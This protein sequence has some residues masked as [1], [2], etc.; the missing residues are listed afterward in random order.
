LIFVSDL[1]AGS[2][3]RPVSAD[4]HFLDPPWIWDRWLA[5]E[6][7]D[8]APKLVEDGDGGQ[9]WLY[10]GS[11]KP[12]PIGLH[13]LPG[14]PVDALRPSGV[15]YSEV[16]PGTYD[17]SARLL[18]LDED[19]VAA[20]VIFPTSRPLAHFLDDHDRGFLLAGVEAYNRFVIEEFCAAAP[21][22]LFAVAQLPS[23]GADDC[24]RTL[25]Q[26]AE[27]GFVSVVLPGWPSGSDLMR[28]EDLR[29]WKCAADLDMPVCI[30]VA[31][32]SREERVLSLEYNKEQVAQPAGE[33]KSEPRVGG[34]RSTI[35]SLEA[36]HRLPNVGVAM[37]KG[38][39]ALSELL[40]SGLFE[41]CPSLKVGL[42]ETWVGWIPRLLEAL[43]DVWYR[44]RHLHGSPLKEPPSHYW[45]SNVAASFLEDRF[46]LGAIGTIG[47]RNM[48]WSTDYPHFGTFWPQSVELA[49]KSTATLDETDRDLVLR[50]NC[51][52]F[53]GIRPRM[54]AV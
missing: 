24:V 12:S 36:H 9:G 3:P 10:A 29:F 45:H 51:L 34:A 2:R 8:R 48:M 54:A 53:Y 20:E 6:Y 33:A 19:G 35:H 47:A 27:Q 49:L 13:G 1:Q 11:S 39:A 52:D 41:S 21:N 44:S 31:L 50:E 46:G 15:S 38:A 40:L 4:S 16:R 22:R 26:A 5:S 43:D 37:G 30:H 18:D 42:I 14:R 23:T 32:R 17:G 7:R 28:A 25:Q